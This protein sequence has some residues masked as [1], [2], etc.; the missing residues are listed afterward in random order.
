MSSFIFK[1]FSGSMRSQMDINFGRWLAKQRTQAG[2][3]QKDVAAKCRLSDPYITRLESGSTEPPPLKT[4][5]ALARAL[6][7]QW[8]ELWR[9]A[10]A[11]RLEKWIKRQGYSH[12]SDAVLL[13]IAKRIEEAD[14]QPR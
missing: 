10:F 5:K 11:A 14:K 6:S 8:E 13:E 12:I 3:T 4:C 1:T 7:I 2:L 9:R